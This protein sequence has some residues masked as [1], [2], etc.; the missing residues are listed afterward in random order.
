[1][2][3]RVTG[4]LCRVPKWWYS[5]QLTRFS[6]TQCSY[7]SSFVM[8]KVHPFLFTIDMSDDSFILSTQSTLVCWG[9]TKSSESYLSVSWQISGAL[10]KFLTVLSGCG[11]GRPISHFDLAHQSLLAAQTRVREAAR[12][13]HRNTIFPY[14]P[15]RDAG[16]TR[17]VCCF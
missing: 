17:A 11:G 14:H 13:S 7:W 15:S 4:A 9:W 5:S 2:M 12:F 3:A 6:Y 10:K 1:M 8:E 16:N